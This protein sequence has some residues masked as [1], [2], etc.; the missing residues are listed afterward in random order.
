MDKIK[1]GLVTF[2]NNANYGGSLQEFASY[3][4]LNKEY[5]CKCINYQDE[6]AL[7]LLK[8]IRVGFLIKMFMVAKELLGIGRKKKTRDE[9]PFPAV[10]KHRITFDL[11]TIRTLV[12]EFFNRIYLMLKDILQYPIRKRLINNYKAFWEQ[13]LVRTRPY[14]EEELLSGL[15]EK[16][17]VYIS[18]SDQIWNPFY[19][20]LSPIYYLAFSPDKAK[21]VSFAPSF[22]NF[23]YNDIQLNNGIREYLSRFSYITVREDKSVQDLKEHIGIDVTTMLDPTLMLD[24]ND[25]I[26]ALSINENVKPIKG[27]VLVYALSDRHKL[28]QI[29]RMVGEKLGLDTYIMDMP[30]LFTSKA[31][32]Y[33][34]DISPREFVEKLLHA[35]FVV[36]NSF[37]GTAFSVNFNIPF[38]FV[39]SNTPERQKS[40]L[41]FVGLEDRTIN[42]N[43]KGVTLQ[44]IV[45]EKAN[46]VLSAKRM[47]DKA[48]LDSAIF[49][50]QAAEE[51]V[52]TE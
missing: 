31:C 35:S 23:K 27:Y 9:K 26:E 25:W 16:F 30:G 12:L 5:D 33:F 50:R 47:Y 29:G 32:K 2:S 34:P 43:V 4:L 22:G 13:Y 18:G 42:K 8:P 21:R 49:G 15:C 10:T 1:V 11:K 39:I 48:S 19:V 20:G 46:K 7:S 28:N 3:Y 36:T 40:L 51:G 44:P 24:R 17:D 52:V 6:L 37:H 41:K 38:Y 45:F 14:T